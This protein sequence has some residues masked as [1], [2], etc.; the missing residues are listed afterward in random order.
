MTSLQ[1]LATMKELGVTV[2]LCTPSYAL[3]L[4][5]VAQENGIDPARDLSVRVGIHAGE[6]GAGIPAT[7]ERIE[8]LWG[9]TVYDHPGA[10][11]VGAYGFSCSAREGVHVNEAEYIAEVIDPATGRAVAPGEEGELVLTNLGR[12]C[13][14]VVRYRSGDVVRPRERGQCACGRT[15][16]L[17]EGGI[18]GRSDD[19]VTVRGVNVFPAAFQ[20]IFNRIPGVGEHRVS[21]YREQHLDQLHVEFECTDGLELGEAVAKAIRDSLG[22]RVS[23]AQCAPESLPRFELKARRFLD[24]RAEGW[25]PG[26]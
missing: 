4:A 1:R 17:L 8:T 15:S 3:H 21:A 19:M 12:H 25:R 18:L 22:I 7:R 2:L 14:P 6:P 9:A 23:L 5:E 20:E 13:F 26:R 16:L 24:R 10:S 11:E